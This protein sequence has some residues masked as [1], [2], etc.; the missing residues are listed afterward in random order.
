MGQNDTTR[1]YKNLYTKRSEDQGNLYQ[2]INKLKFELAEGNTAT[3]LKSFVF[4]PKNFLIRNQ[5]KKIPF[6]QVLI[7]LGEPAFFKNTATT[8]MGLNYATHTDYFDIS[9]ELKNGVWKIRNFL[10]KED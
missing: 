2:L 6:Q 4:T 10:K 5:L 8:M 7:F 3:L 9:F 1:N